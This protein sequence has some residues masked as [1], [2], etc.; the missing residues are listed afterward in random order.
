LGDYQP[1]SASPHDTLKNYMPRQLVECVPN[2]SEG[3]DAAKIDA[4]VASVLAVPEVALLDRES[5][6]DHNRSVLTFVGPPAAVA[7]AAFRSVE[8]AV[9]LIDLT[10]HQGAHP[11]IGA[12]DVVPFIPIEGVTLEDCV[13]LAER[14][15]NQIWN[16]LKVPV[17]HYEAA[18][19]RPER[20][21]LE[22]IRRGQF[23]ALLKEMGTVPGRQPD[24]GDAVCH[25]TAGAIVVGARKFLIA[26][27]VNL[28]TPDVAIAKKIAKTIRFS[29]GGF[30][31][32]KSMGVTLASRNLAQVSINLTDFEQTPMHLVYETVRRE[33]E[34][35]GVPV[36][37]SEIVGL[38]PKKAIE[39]SAEYFLR[40]E[41]FRP[42]LVLENRIA[43][44]MGLPKT[45]RGGLPEFLD[46]LA[47]PTAT[48]GGGSASAAAAAMGA[49][50]GSMVTRL[51]KQDSDSFEEDRRFFTEAVELD[52]EAFQKVMAAYKRPKEERAP[53]VEEALHGAAEVPL[54]V[55]E[56]AAAMLTRL[57]RLEIPAKFGSD[58]AVA[59]ALT[60]AAK[61]GVL[62]NV[63]I[64]LDSI[65]DQAF[66][67][68]VQSRLAAVAM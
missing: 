18:A 50:L 9:S 49:A 20:V 15:G 66:Q 19:K 11:R 67:A 27:N 6:A 44:A 59:K 51:A 24:C 17:Y 4:I 41:N 43:D 48:P 38:I 3:R 37:G 63:R 40:F 32:V 58:L 45:S 5:D 29:S 53:F 60:A 21:N 25:P 64:N 30:R 61:A 65:K 42:E 26:Y 52:A 14:L 7:E 8:T 1:H 12:A 34:R 23:E 33:A 47:A 36:V 10:T 57:E 2:F 28:G 31:F 54:Q 46:A 55:L 56:R 13:K 35:Y 39:M 22:N 68:S 62:E 16:K